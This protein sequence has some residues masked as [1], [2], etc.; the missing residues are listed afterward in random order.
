MPNKAF[1][2]LKLFKLLVFLFIR[3]E[4][5][6][7]GKY[8][9]K[10]PDC[11]STDYWSDKDRGEAGCSKCGRVFDDEYTKLIIGMNQGP[12]WRAF[13]QQ[14]KDSRSRVGTP[15]SY[16]VYDKGLS[17]AISRVDRDAHGRKLPLSTRLQMWRLKKWHIRSRAHTSVDRNLAQAMT[18]LDR[19][20]DRLY[21][22][23]PIKEKAAVVYRKAL[24]KGTVR[25]RSIAGIAAASMHYAC[26]ATGTPRSLK[27]IAEASL[28]DKGVVA[29]YYRVL[30]REL[31]DIPMPNPDLLTYASKIAERAGVSG[32]T[33][34][35][36]FRILNE[37][38]KKHIHHG[39]D[40]SGLVVAALYIACLQNNEKKIQKDLAEVAGVTEVTLRN[41]F[42][43]IKRKLG[44]KIP[45]LRS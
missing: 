39:K 3:I 5:K 28:V 29:R 32:P 13:T 10:C 40:P 11:G 18:E 7:V 22:P 25:G 20:S 8:Q 37:V 30:L 1:V 31:D 21:I 38:K 12:E 17:T 15:T 44:L 27:E 36:A 33:Q 42:K 16:S 2:K 41:R 35:I 34:G 45:D 6:E 23:A 19:L 43:E 14:E 9:V 26:R 4:M 24:E